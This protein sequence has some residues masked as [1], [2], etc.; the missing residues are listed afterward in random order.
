MECT[1]ERKK[2]SQIFTFCVIARNIRR[3]SRTVDN[4]CSTVIFPSRNFYSEKERIRPFS[5]YKFCKIM[6]L[7]HVASET[8]FSSEYVA[9]SELPLLCASFRSRIDRVWTCT[10]ETALFC[11][12]I[13]FYLFGITGVDQWPTREPLWWPIV[14]RQSRENTQV[15]C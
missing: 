5:L 15:F 9:A 3:L 10:R 7:S 8:F 2:R 13:N 1:F 14:F 6:R 11:N 4:A 12:G